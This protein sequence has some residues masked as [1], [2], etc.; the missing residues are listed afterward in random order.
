[1]TSKVDDSLD[2][3]MESWRLL[4][5]LIQM[6]LAGGEIEKLCIAAY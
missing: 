1:M 5:Q 4:R 3:L 6:A 2:Y